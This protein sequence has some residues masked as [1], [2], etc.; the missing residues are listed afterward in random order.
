MRQ[1]MAIL[2]VLS[3]NLFRDKGTLITSLLLPVLFLF[4]FGFMYSP[5]VGQLDKPVLAYYLDPS[6]EGIDDMESALKNLE[7]ILKQNAMNS[8]QKVDEAISSG[9]ANFGMLF[10][11]PTIELVLDSAR[12]Q[13]NSYYQ[14]LGQTILDEYNRLHVN[15]VNIITTQEEE[16]ATR[17]GLTNL[18]YLIPGIMALGIFSTSLFGFS[19]ILLNFKEKGVL[20]RISATPI[21]QSLFIL[22][23]MIT[24]FILVGISM[25]IIVLIAKGI[26]KLNLSIN[27]LLFP[28]YILLA[29]LGMMSFGLLI[30]LIARSAKNAAEIGS[31]LLTIMT[32]FSGVYYPIEFLPSYFRIFSKILPLT[33]VIEGL[34]YVIH[35]ANISTLRFGLIVLGFLLLSG[36]ILPFSA[37]RFKWEVS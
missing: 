20:K 29:T 17:K 18:D 13:N 24:R 4:I 9:A 21:N 23:L 19:T 32:F 26:F 33:Y 34:H 25:V 31:I 11:H 2:S 22:G 15:T 27:W 28:P 14:Q 5:Q 30:S 7:E 35:M 12:I 1:F 10:S 37:R 6:S 16:V 36:I 8:A 3:K